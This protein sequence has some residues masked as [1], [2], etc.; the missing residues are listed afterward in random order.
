MTDVPGIAILGAG[1]FAKEAHLPA[2]AALGSS[3]PPLRAVYSRSEKSAQDLA[4]AATASLNLSTSPAA[5]H[6]GDTSTNLDALLSRNDITAIIVAL[7]ITTQP[8]IIIKALAAG[9]HVLS[10]KPVAPDVQSGLKLIADYETTYKPKGLIWRV[11]ENFEAEPG[12][13]AVGEV[14]RSGKI[15]EVQSFKAVVINY[16][17]KESKWYKSPWRTIPDYQGGFL[18]DGGVHTTAA[19]RVMLPHPLTHLSGFSSLNKDY[20]APHDTVHTIVKAGPK[21]RGTAELTWASPTKSRPTADG[22]VIS[23]SNGWISVNQ[24]HKPGSNAPIIR[25]TIHSNFKSDSGAEE[26]KEEVI[27]ELY[28]GVKAELTSFFAAIKGQDDGK[29]LGDPLAALSDVAFVQAA[30]NSEG[31]L[32]DLTQLIKG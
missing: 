16:M 6:D 18:L 24:I 13:R 14:V 28:S 7:P 3:A 4:Q 11:A 27:E 17:D 20:L 30:L 19:L 31:N 23:G 25:A 9:K 1:I 5:Y 26:E 12:Y 32:V 29:N 21:I 10:E 22:F 2:L 8:S 15:G